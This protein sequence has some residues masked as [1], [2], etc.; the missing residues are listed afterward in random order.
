MPDYQDQLLHVEGMS[1]AGCENR[2]ARRL[3]A[4]EGVRKVMADARKAEVRVLFDSERVDVAA[5]SSAIA[6]LGYEVRP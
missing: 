2:V 5:I 3:G 1:C 6:A 4:L